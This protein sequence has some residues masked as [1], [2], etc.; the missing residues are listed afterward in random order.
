MAA[1]MG[2][3]MKSTGS[4]I[5]GIDGIRAQVVADV[6]FT[7][8][9]Q[10]SESY[11][12]EKTAVRSEQLFEESSDLPGAM[13]IPGALSNQPPPGGTTEAVQ[14]ELQTE[15]GMT[16]PP[17]RNASRSVR[18]FEVDRTISHTRNSPVSLRKLSVAVVVDYR[19]SQDGEGKIERIPL[20][21]AEMAHITALVRE[22]VGLNDARGDTINVVNTPFQ[23]AEEIEP[24]P[25]VPIW[26]QAWVLSLAKQ[27][28]HICRIGIEQ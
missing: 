18:N 11:L 26:E 12:P 4:P 22:A 17:M 24:L 9:E 7:A 13:G 21:A 23:L 8:Q 14:T 27:I 28:I 6:D 15:E 5:V 1:A 2:I 3:Q 20:E 10:T 25:D 16:A 19:L